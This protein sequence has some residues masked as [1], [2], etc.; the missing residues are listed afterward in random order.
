MSQ[1][2]KDDFAKKLGYKDYEDLVSTAYTGN[3]IIDPNTGV[4]NT[5][6]I[7]ASVVI[8]SKLLADAIMTST[9]NVNNNL[10]IEKDGSVRTKGGNLEMILTK[11]YLRGL[12]K[13]VERLR[14]VIDESLGDSEL[15]LTDRD[16]FRLIQ[17][18]GGNIHFEKRKDIIA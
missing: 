4:F 13:D 17:E 15:Y 8:T 2:V 7:E 6:L 12:Y 1:E 18:L 16:P 11:G 14:L 10:Y 5:R 9:L 3:T